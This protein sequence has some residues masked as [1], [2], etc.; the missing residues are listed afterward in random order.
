MTDP[1]AIV[2]VDSEGNPESAY[3]PGALPDPEGPWSEDKTKTIAY[4]LEPVEDLARFMKTRYWKNNQWNDREAPDGAWY[5]WKDEAWV[6]N[7]T[8]LF[9]SIRYDRDVLLSQSDW[10][11]LDDCK[12]SMEKK[13]EW[14]VYRQ[15][16]RDIPAT[17][18]SV[19]EKSS[20]T[21]PTKPS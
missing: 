17:Y 12:L 20:I 9:E 11:Q 15:A 18:S 19:T 8:E 10:T 13:G 2:L 3:H 1:H 21:W 6:L 7:S 16:L 14:A 4:V 5:T